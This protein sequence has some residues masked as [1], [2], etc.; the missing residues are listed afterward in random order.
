MARLHCIFFDNTLCHGS[1]LLKVG[2]TQ[3]LLGLLESERVNPDLILDDPVLALRQWSHDPTLAARA[4][5][6][7]GRMLTAIEL[8]LLFL[9]E[10][11]RSADAGGYDGIVP[12]AAE[13]LAFWEDTLIRLRSGDV[14]G[15]ASRLDWAL[16]LHIL[17][18]A[19]TRR[20]G[21]GWSDPAL[22][23]LDHLYSNLDPANG[24]YWAYEE[25][26]AVERL[27]S[28]ADIERFVHE[29]PE[30]T[31]AWGRAMLLRI[32]GRQ[33]QDVDW[34]RVR[35]RQP[36]RGYW[37]TLR[38]VMLDDPLRFTRATMAPVIDAADSLDELLDALGA[39]PPAYEST[40]VLSP[41]VPPASSS[42]GG[43][44]PR[45]RPDHEHT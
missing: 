16:K 38:T 14:A 18:Q 23:H 13:I 27:V 6:A 10:A 22:K 7:S 34:D 5:T 45:R 17:E 2:T 11:Q 30:D 35:F 31:R 8:Q 33:V 12:R 19:M 36:G 9:E 39:T 28:D 21:L 32:G 42:N 44:H 25:I 15:L 3:L 41:V 24:L 4:R 26:G 40:P 29:P 37:P 1:T 43:A 20:P